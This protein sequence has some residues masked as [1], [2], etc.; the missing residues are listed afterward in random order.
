M[1][2]QKELS[3]FDRI[4]FV[5]ST[6]S[7]LIDGQPTHDLSVTRLIKKFKREF[8]Q[9]EMAAR[10]AKKRKTTID[11]IL[12]EWEMNRL[13]SSTI[14]TLLH[15]YV[16]SFYTKQKFDPVF[17]SD[18]LAFE[19]KQKL[20]TNLPVLIEYFQKFYNDNSH[21]QCIK[22]EFIVGDLDDTKLCGTADMLCLNT[23]DNTIELLDFKTNKKLD[24]SSKYAKLFYPFGDMD[25]CEINEYTIQLNTY[26]Y[27]IEKYTNI[28]VEKMKLIW[29]Q[30]T[31]NSYQIIELPCIQNKINLMFDRFK[32]FSL[33]EE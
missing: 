20:K 32:S 23:Q 33:F 6:H 17:N 31:N 15:K 24:S 10:V 30:A 18:V 4:C 12:A 7:Y 5:E 2:W 13:Y 1:D 21:L 9:K 28:K 8:K 29:L 3:V 19:E 26:K 22:N 25:E 11:H 14:G 16:E 27:F